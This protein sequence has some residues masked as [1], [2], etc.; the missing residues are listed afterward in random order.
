METVI[1]CVDNAK[2][3]STIAMTQSYERALALQ[4]KLWKEQNIDTYITKG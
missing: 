2:D 1:Y 3:G 4:D